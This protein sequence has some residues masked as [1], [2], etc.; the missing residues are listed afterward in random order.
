MTCVWASP[1]RLRSTFTGMPALIAYAPVLARARVLCLWEAFLS[2][3]AARQ[4]LVAS[5]RE[6]RV[7]YFLSR[8]RGSRAQAQ[9]KDNRA[10][11][12]IE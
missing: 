2:L 1:A 9:T 11:A 10:I 5:R 7:V 3:H 12:C 6:P 4:P 8:K